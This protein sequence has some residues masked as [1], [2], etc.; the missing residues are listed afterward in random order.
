MKVSLW[1]NNRDIRV[2]DA[3]VPEPG[4]GE[5][6]LKV[7]ACGICGSD[8][9]EW[10]RLP[11]APLVQGHEIG[12]CV[13]KVGAGVLDFKPGDRVMAA[14]KVPCLKCSHC[15]DGHFPQC[16]EVKE[17]LGGGFAQYVLVPKLIVENGL[18]H[19]PASISCEQATF[20]EPLAC[21]VRAAR[22]GGAAEGKTIL[23]LGSGVSGLLHIRLARLRNSAVAATD[24]NPQKL[25]LAGKAGAQFLIPGREDVPARLAKQAGRKADVVMV[26]TGALPAIEQAWRSVDKGGSIVFFAVP[27]PDISVTMPI[28][29]FWT[30]EVRV[31]TSYYCGPPDIREA[32]E[33]LAAGRIEVDS[34]VT[35]RLPLERIAEGFALLLDGKDA[36]KVIIEPNGPSR[37]A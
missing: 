14:P 8:L 31:L 33:L 15:R 26:C 13:E 32:I 10:Y 7:M 9:V 28:N 34:L 12:A 30:Q 5:V 3:P 27:G 16:S 18:Y 17:R 24:V 36:V 2:Q 4:P 22:I 21:V 25:V 6:L 23:I 29:D 20:I 1:Y 37:G 35:H 19:L 11:R